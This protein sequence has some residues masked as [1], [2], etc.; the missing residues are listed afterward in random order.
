MPHPS[1][2]GLLLALELPLPLQAVRVSDALRERASTQPQR[3]GVLLNA[4]RPQ[5]LRFMPALN[6]SEQEIA[7]G[8][9][10]LGEQLAATSAEAHAPG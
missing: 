4:V 10:A 9:D 3:S 7:L 2:R 8:L 6:I 1:G 5:R